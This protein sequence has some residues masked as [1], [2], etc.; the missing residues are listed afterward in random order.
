MEPNIKLTNVH[1][2]QNDKNLWKSTRIN[3]LILEHNMFAHDTS[4]TI[5]IKEVPTTL[6]SIWL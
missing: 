2:K 3:R 1:I 6:L 4:I 5:S